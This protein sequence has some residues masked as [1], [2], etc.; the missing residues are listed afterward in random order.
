[1]SLEFRVLGD[2]P[3]IEANTDMHQILVLPRINAPRHKVVKLETFEPALDQPP[4]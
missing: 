3:A 2:M 1:M 4:K